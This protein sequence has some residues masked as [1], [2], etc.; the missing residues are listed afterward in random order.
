LPLQLHHKIENHLYIYTE[1]EFFKRPS[2]LFAATY[3]KRC[4][5]I[6]GDFSEILVAFW[7]LKI[8]LKALN[9]ST[10]YFSISFL[11]Y[12]AIK[13][14]RLFQSNNIHPDAV[15]RATKLDPKTSYSLV[16][17]ARSCS[18]QCFFVCVA[19]F[20]HFFSQRN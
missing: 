8:F 7:L 16:M 10:F 5:A 15:A 4:I 20:C 12:I 17:G 6:Y 19:K 2:I 13:K 11:L 14:E 1:V 3:L 18:H 9:S